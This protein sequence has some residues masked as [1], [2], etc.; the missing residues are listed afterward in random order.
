MNSL[1]IRE[2]RESIIRYANS[3]PFPIEVKRLIFSE[4][5]KQLETTAN[6]EIALLIK[7][8]NKESE[9]L[10]QDESEVAEDEQSVQSD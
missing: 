3:L 10:E 8:R 2:A 9:N 7:K 4:V 6:Q 1:E 5:F